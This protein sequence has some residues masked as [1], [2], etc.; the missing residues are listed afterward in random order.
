MEV[1][2]NPI[3]ILNINEHTGSTITDGGVT[4]NKISLIESSQNKINTG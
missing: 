2:T 1:I 4:D 3:I